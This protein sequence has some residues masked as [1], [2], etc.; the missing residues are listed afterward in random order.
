MKGKRRLAKGGR[1]AKGAV[2][3]TWRP[4]AETRADLLQS[5]N[6]SKVEI[7]YWTLRRAQAAN[8]VDRVEAGARL[9]LW[10]GN[11]EAKRR[12]LDEISGR[13]LA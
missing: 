6:D 12:R 2:L 4:R 5:I 9:L 11:L 3:P 10:N 13:A 7:E 1:H 8:P